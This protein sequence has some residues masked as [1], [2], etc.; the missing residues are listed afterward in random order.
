[1]TMLEEIMVEK[2]RTNKE[3]N[4]NYGC[5]QIIVTSNFN[6][7]QFHV[8]FIRISIN[9]VAS[10]SSYKQQSHQQRQRHNN[11]SI[12]HASNLDSLKKCDQRHGTSLRN[13]QQNTHTKQ[14][15]KQ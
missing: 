9:N 14:H 11:K 10:F 5:K 12:H 13:E 2:P 4:E 7:V 15:R 1:M 8:I 3:M 6:F